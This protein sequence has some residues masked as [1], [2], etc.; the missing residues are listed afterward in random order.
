VGTKD[1][2]L[3]GFVK[4]IFSGQIR[5]ELIFPFPRL[6]KD[7]KETIK[8]LLQ[9]LSDFINKEY[10]FKKVLHER[11]FSNN[12][13]EEIKKN[14]LYSLI[15]PEKFNGLGFSMTS[16]LRIL[17]DV[18]KYSFSLATRISTHQ[19][20]GGVGILLKGS[21]F[22]KKRY[23]PIIASGEKLFGFALTESGI[24][25]DVK[26][27]K[28]TAEYVARKNGYLL[29]GSKIWVFNAPEAEVFIVFAKT[30]LPQYLKNKDELTAFVVEKSYGVKVAKPEKISG[31]IGLEVAQIF[32]DNVFVPKENI[33][34]EEGEGF[35]VAVETLNYG[36]LELA[37]EALGIAKNA[38]KIASDYA[39]HRK[40]FGNNISE[41]G[42]IQE[43]IGSMSID[44]YIL[45]S[46]VY[47]TAGLIDAKDND[48]SVEAAICKIFAAESVMKTVD[49]A[50]SI[51]SSVAFLEDHWLSQIL[52]DLRMMFFFQGTNEV[53]RLF[54]AY[55]GLNNSATG[56][57]ISFTQA[58]TEPLKSLG[59]LSDLLVKKISA[60]VLTNRIVR[61]DP[62]LKKE[63]SIIEEVI[64]RFNVHI[65]RVIRKYGNEI[66]QQQFIIKK[67]ADVSIKIYAMS[68]VTSRVSDYILDNGK[69]N[70]IRE[71]EIAV[72]V[73]DK[74][75]KEIINIFDSFETNKD[76]YLKDAAQKVYKYQKYKYDIID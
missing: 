4:G 59:I 42:M 11:K 67:I 47:L 63:A 58:L 27:I 20:M 17:E 8:I 2:N 73:A 56:E 7:E 62:L 49:S 9:S 12:L 41:Y 50:T 74:Y 38:I 10:N 75:Y 16:Y 51:C 71:I 68:A 60:S 52:R 29:N 19:I 45:E 46:M 1:D 14:G 6:S 3:R 39:S 15:I 53:L 5:E 44:T 40:Q 35:S 24:G 48:Y 69:E 30:T 34:S 31:L 21:S 36:R 13:K 61:V 72:Y 37:S 54:I 26:S 66:I 65:E 76:E 23:L 55:S 32:L 43:K 70:S 64:E 25:S 28:T 18:S 22:L 57:E 33:I